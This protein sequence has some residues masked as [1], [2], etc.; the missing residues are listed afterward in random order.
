METMTGTETALELRAT[1]DER[2]WAR[3]GM[4]ASFTAAI[5]FL[6]VTVLFLLDA[7]DLLDRSPVYVTTPSGQLKDEARF[8]GAVFEHQHRIVWDVIVRDLVGPAAFVALIV[9]GVALARRAGGDD[10]A[11][12]LMVVFLSAGGLISAIASLL[13]LG[14]VEF[15]RLPW[16]PIAPDAET[17]VIAVGRA[18]TAI[19]NLTVWPEAFGYLVLAAGV[20]CISSVVRRGSGMP[21]RLATLASVTGG[22]L[23]AL[24]V[25]TMA[26]TDTPRS[27]LSFAVGAVLAPWLCVWLGLVLGRSGGLASPGRGRS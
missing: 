1:S 18:T 20:L 24:A 27:V 9:V 7:L 22:G 12:R 4:I 2:A 13:Y 6:V 23:A 5:G 25:A 19:D 17:S 14:N 10:P 16:G 15:W 3:V 26:D 8:W 21:R 11:R